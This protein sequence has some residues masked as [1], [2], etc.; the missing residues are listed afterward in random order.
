MPAIFYFLFQHSRS[1]QYSQLLL[2]L[3]L[4]ITYFEIKPNFAAKLRNAAARHNTPNG[5]ISAL[6]E[7]TEENTVVLK[8]EKAEALHGKISLPKGCVFTDGSSEKSAENGE[9]IVCKQEGIA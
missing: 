8:I 1:F 3:F 4:N 2:L 9:Y 5:E 7:R 6:W